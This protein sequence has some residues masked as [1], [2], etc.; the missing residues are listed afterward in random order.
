MPWSKSE[1]RRRR[2]VGRRRRQSGAMGPGAQPATRRKRWSAGSGR[3]HPAWP[4]SVEKRGSGRLQRR[5]LRHRGP[6][7]PRLR[8]AEFHLYRSA[9]MNAASRCASASRRKK[10]PCRAALSLL[11][12]RNRRDRQSDGAAA[13]Y[14]RPHGPVECRPDAQRRSE[15][16]QRAVLG[17][18]LGYRSEGLSLQCR[19]PGRHAAAGGRSAMREVVGRRP[20]PGYLPRQP[21]GDRRGREKHDPGDDGHLRP[22]GIS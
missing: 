3:D 6:V 14:R 19:E 10:S 12:A 16:R 1:W 2:P 18:V 11:A 5:D 20:G 8:S 13:E 15:H 7:G 21:P 17:A 22:P 9:G 4:G